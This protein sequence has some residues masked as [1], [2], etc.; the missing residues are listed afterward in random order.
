MTEVLVL[1]VVGI[2][3][4]AVIGYVLALARVPRTLA[5]MTGDELHALAIKV[6]ERRHV[7]R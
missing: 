3:I 5:T 1:L 6:E 2:V 4:G 7:R